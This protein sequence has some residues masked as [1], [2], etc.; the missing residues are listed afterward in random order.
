M[1]NLKLAEAS[2]FGKDMSQAV[3]FKRRIILISIDQRIQ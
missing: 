2:S 1:T 3:S